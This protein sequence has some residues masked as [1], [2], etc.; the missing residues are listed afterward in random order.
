MAPPYLRT[1]TS[2][3]ATPPATHTRMVTCS[4]AKVSPLKETPGDTRTALSWLCREIFNGIDDDCRL[5]R[6][7]SHDSSHVLLHVTLDA[8]PC[9]RL[10]DHHPLD[11]HVTLGQAQVAERAL[12]C[13][14]RR[15]AG[16]GCFGSAGLIGRRRAEEPEPESQR[17]EM[18]FRTTGRPSTT[19]LSEPSVEPSSSKTTF[20]GS[21]WSD[22]TRR[23]F[24]AKNGTS[25]SSAPCFSASS[26][27]VRRLR[28]H[29]T[30]GSLHH[31]LFLLERPS[32][33]SSFRRDM[34]R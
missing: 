9:R 33:T 29:R 4:V 18:L 30:V 2:N 6:A 23:T 26:A 28:I 20:N 8:K 3:A 17:V 31:A 24:V 11:H 14:I 1:R 13:R 32:E 27:L 22:L 7:R 16:R 34:A 15:S 12:T 5:R 19:N 25:V 21:E 10:E